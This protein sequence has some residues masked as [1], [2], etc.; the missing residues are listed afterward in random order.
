MNLKSDISSVKG[1]GEKTSVVFRDIGINTVE[2]L[3]HYYPRT[4]EKFENITA[5]KD[6]ISGERNA[7]YGCL[8][9]D[10]KM[11]RFSGKTMI[12]AYARDKDGNSIE[13]KY[14]NANYLLKIL[15]RGSFYVFRGYVKAVGARYMMTQPQMYKL[16]EY[17]KLQGT[18]GPIYSST[19]DLSAAR[20]AKNIQNCIDVRNEY[21]E[22]LSSDE[23]AEGNM[24]GL[25]ESLYNIHM[26]GNEEMLYKARRRL[27]FEEFLDFYKGFRMQEGGYERPQNKNPFVEVADCKRLE[28]RLPFA[29]TYAQKKAIEEIIEDITGPYLMNRLVQGDVGSGK[30]LVA[31]MA[32]ITAAANNA[33]GALMAPTEVLAVQ[34]YTNIMKMSSD[35]GLCIKPV[36]LFGKMP[37]KARTEVLEKIRTGEANVIIGTHALFQD[38]VEFKNLKL[39]ITDEQHRFG[40][41]QR[42]A[43]RDKG[44]DAHILV[45]S[46]T[47]IPR[48]LA[49][50][51][52]GNVDISIMN[53][54]PKN[55]LP[56]NNC[57]VDS[58]FQKK[59]LDFIESEI[60]KGHQAYIICPMIDESEED[61]FN[62]KNV[63]EFTKELKE[64]YG[65][66]ARIVCLHGKMKSDE[67]NRIMDSFKDGLYD[68]LVSTT[69]IEVGVDVPNATVI[70]IENAERFGLSQLHQLRGR[71]GRGDSQSYCILVSDAKNQESISR[72]KV[73]NET[74][75]GFEIARKDIELR[76]PGELSGVKQSGALSFSLGDIMN[77]SDVFMLVINMYDRI[78]E[79]IKDR[80]SRRIDF[81]TI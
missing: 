30:T 45:M 37:K 54:L 31:L 35:Y 52:Y 25:A 56:I 64:H 40:V 5:I 7:V 67:K 29:L 12:T 33:Q 72:L 46:A 69:V 44:I 55:R 78:F 74:N 14:F 23:M 28:D 68:I 3:I 77:D 11:L 17:E 9:S 2:D 47:P 16:D 76:G 57:V 26:P 39:V 8:I 42:E 43:L 22:Y 34:H 75:D 19:K 21:E 48:T 81:R 1:V 58:S 65:D 6:V 4:Y 41:N 71:V 79:R 49:M 61:N 50:V 70:M 27:V 32:L 24:L 63:T 10:A 51:M 66:R 80:V 62:L 13:I 60:K 38:E 15:K 59:S 73:L 20:I 18:I 36:I 53:E